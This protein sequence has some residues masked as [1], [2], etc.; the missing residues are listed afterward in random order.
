MLTTSAVVKADDLDVS[1]SLEAKKDFAGAAAA[2]QRAYKAKGGYFYA[3]RAGYLFGL[4]G[5]W[6]TSGAEYLEAAALERGAIEPLLGAQ[7]AFATGAEWP[8]A[9]EIGK[10]AVALDATNYLARS[11]L[12][13]AAYQAKDFAASADAYRAVLKLYPGDVDMRVGLGWA[14]LGAGKKTE[15]ALVFREVLG[16]VPKH[17]SATSG[18]AAAGG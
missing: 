16:M 13:W 1:Y 15:A 18:L 3:L 2:M 5:D 11:R 12:A 7:L 17:A 8:K 14:L 4:A 10:R 9:V 6:R